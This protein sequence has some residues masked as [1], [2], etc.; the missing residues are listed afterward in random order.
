MTFLLE[1]FEERLPQRTG[2]DRIR[3]TGGA[4]VEGFP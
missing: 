4:Q 3:D 1:E 2:A